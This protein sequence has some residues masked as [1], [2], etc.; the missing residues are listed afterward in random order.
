MLRSAD[1][2]SNPQIKQQLLAKV[3]ADRANEAEILVLIGEADHRKMYADEG[4][5]SMFVYCVKGFHFSKDVAFK[6]IHAAR[7]ARD[8]PLLIEAVADGRLHLSAVRLI[9]PHLT[10][11]NVDEL[12]AAATHRTCDEIE[13][14]IARRFVRLETLL[15]GQAPRSAECHV[16]QPVEVASMIPQQAARP[17]A[18]ELLELGQAMSEPSVAPIAPAR[19]P[20][21]MRWIA[22]SLS[23][24]EKLQRAQALTSGDVSSVVE[25]AMDEVILKAE[26]HKFAATA[27][28][29]APGARRP[30]LRARTIPAHVR[31]T[32][33]KRDQ[34]RC[35]FSA[36]SEMRCETREHLEF[37]HIVPLARGGKSSAD[38]LRLRCRAHNQREAD[39]A[40]GKEFM[41]EKRRLKRVARSQDPEA[42]ESAP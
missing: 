27:K 11:Q 1:H 12:V 13:E 17:V 24:Y 33:V 22:I 37:D 18:L 42:G 23:A 5:P 28:P 34:A 25:R 10:A 8:F 32:V 2:L 30:S 29:Q 3:A 6:R 41:E 31:R 21:P 19:Q 40:F 16:P 4:H 9:A 14:M 20:E 26:K 7:A 35:T 38:N 39:R 36:G 15:E